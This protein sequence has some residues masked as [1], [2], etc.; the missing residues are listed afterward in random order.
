MKKRLR[1]NFKRKNISKHKKY[2]KNPSINHF[3]INS[4]FIFDLD[5]VEDFLIKTKNKNNLKVN[6][7]ELKI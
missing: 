7:R 6:Q 5:E 4:K 2:L 3:N 1:R